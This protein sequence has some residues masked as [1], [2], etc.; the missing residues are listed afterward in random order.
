M[1]KKVIVP[2]IGVIALALLFL[3]YQLGKNSTDG[4]NPNPSDNAKNSSQK[5]FA[6]PSEA[7]VGKWESEVAPGD[8]G[9]IG[10]V[11]NPDGTG[12]DYLYDVEQMNMPSHQERKT[13]TFRWAY[14]GEKLVL[15]NYLEIEPSLR[16]GVITREWRLSLSPDKQTITQGTIPRYEGDVLGIVPDIVFRRKQ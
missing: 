3:A 14:N 13:A 5:S 10:Y 7:L 2:V 6:L 12:F 16:L 1:S 9:V 15:S 11:F 4:V 8:K